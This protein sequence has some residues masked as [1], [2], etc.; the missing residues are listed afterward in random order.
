MLGTAVL[1]A[2]PRR[3][4]DAPGPKALYFRADMPPK[5]IASAPTGRL[6]ELAADIIHGI[7]VLYLLRVPVVFGL[8]AG[9]EQH[10][11]RPPGTA[12]GRPCIT[13]NYLYG[14]SV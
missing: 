11:T 1:Q 7:A 5:L 14:S 4:N 9:F 8:R 6:L 2:C 12:E 13:D 3:V 10:L